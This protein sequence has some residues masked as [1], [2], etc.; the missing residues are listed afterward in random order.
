MC[1]RYAIFT[2]EENIEIRQIISEVNSRFKEEA[3]KMKTGENFSYKYC[4][5]NNG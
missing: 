3:P 2:E 5:N 1:G 4:A